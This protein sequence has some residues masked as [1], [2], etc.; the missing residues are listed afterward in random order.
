MK[1]PFKTRRQRNLEL[2]EEIAGHLTLAEREEA[3]AGQSNADA[4]SS[5]RREFG[6][7]S[8]AEETTRDMWG[9]RWFQDFLQDARFAIRTLAK[10]PGFLTVALLT[11]ALGIGATTIMFTLIEGV[12]LRPL[13]YFQ[14]DK[15][16]VMNGHTEMWNVTAF[17]EQ[18]VAYLDFLDCQRASKSLDLAGSVFD[19]GTLSAP[20]EP[21][22]LDLRE[23]SPNL[24]SVLGVPLLKGRAFR[25]EED[26]IGADPVAILG[27]SFWQRRFAGNP[28]TIGSTLVLDEKRYTVVGV[29]EPAFR[30]RG[31]EPDILTP[32]GQAT[33]AYLQ[34][35]R[36]HPVGV[37][38]RL[39]P[40]ASITQAQAE[41][42][43]IGRNLAE[44]FA[45]TNAGRSFIVQPLRP[46]VA[47]VQS[48]LWL[49]FG[50]VALVLLIACANVASL[51]LARAVSRERE[52][53]MRIAL[54]AGRG[55]LV[56]QCLTESMILSLGGA[57]LG[58]ALAAIGVQPF[59]T[60]WPGTL[61]RAEQVQLDGRVLLFALAVSLLSGILFGIA[62]AFRTSIRDVERTLRVAANSV[63]G[64]TRRLHSTFVIVEIALAVILLV[65]AGMLGRTLLRLNS[66]DTGLNIHNVLVTRMALSPATL[67]NPAAIR[68][69]W[70]DV[71]SRASHV[72]GVI[73][74]AT[75]D[76]VPMDQGF[77]QL[78]FW[79]SADVPPENKQPAALASSVSPDY[80]KV[81]GIPLR[82]GRFF[83]DHDRIGSESVVIVDD[84]L[85]RQTF[86]QQDALGKYLWIPHMT[87]G[88][89]RIV[90]VVG[91]VRH[92]GLAGDDQAQVRAQLYYPF[93]QVSDDDLHRWSELMSIAVRTNL[94]PLNMVG[95]LRHELRGATNEQVLYNVRTLEQL[96]SDSIARQRFLFFLFGILAGLALL[97]AS[98]GIYGVLAYLTSQRVPEIGIRMSLGAS[99]RTVLNL[100][101]K[102]SLGMIFTG[103]SIGTFAAIAA[104]R[105]LLRSVQGM[106]PVGSL[107]FLTVI[108][109]LVAAAL[110]ASFVPAR[111]ASRVDPLVA[112]R[113]D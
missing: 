30:L 79:T 107:T 101:L 48:T 19:G 88:P 55:R 43:L 18:N 59:V 85:A 46:N 66:L 53:A 54:G 42:V 84:V 113:H 49:L 70:Q 65:S 40:G 25:P 47:A 28:E 24:F 76:T 62:P 21:E 99:P 60:L 23:I 37:V 93:A 12:L 17:G 50:A 92:W 34:N 6:N 45:D 32:V 61:P 20:G 105:L 4:R 112:L 22:Y 56:R 110:L 104:S 1:W 38:G 36:S 27:Y 15:L 97:L 7:I 89:V 57:I 111:R 95:P 90:G 44:Q 58:I 75:V 63:S 67:T 71:L 102:Q 103:I 78:G 83:D 39:R 98:I 35:R 108:P 9:S 10:R 94:P 51:L 68:A 87:T 100:I 73:A 5:A 64:K 14:P 52:L 74:V 86:G 106:Q 11:L 109:V 26:H 29:T 8:V 16:V 13:P 33:A 91:H 81:M 2:E 77:N 96:A 41:L 82:E 72:P 3:Q 69:A 31:S 80:L